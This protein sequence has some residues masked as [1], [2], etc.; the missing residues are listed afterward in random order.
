VDCRTFLCI[1]GLLCAVGCKSELGECDDTA[2]N[3][4][5]YNSSYRIATKGQALAQDSCGNSAFCHSVNAR[6]KSRHGAPG[7]MNFDMLP[8]PTGLN[9]MR[10]H[11]ELS[12]SAVERGV[13]PPGGKVGRAAIGDGKWLTD[14]QRR[15][16]ATALPPLASDAGKG[17]FRNWLAC[18]APVVVDERV[19]GQMPEVEPTW[20]SIYD[21]VIVGAGCASAGCHNTATSSGGLSLE[22]ACN[23]YAALLDKSS[24]GEVYVRPNMAAE[25][26]LVNVLEASKPRCDIDP[27]P[28]TGPLDDSAMAAIRAWIAAGAQAEC[29]N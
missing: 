9:A 13:M 27:M 15:P 6:G 2:A 12:W 11:A 22:G 26:L 7:G 16:G 4:L 24:C 21:N 20:P 25:S 17:I 3:E 14:P 29:S 19:P 1:A 10:E 8:T 5:V 28:P 18:G 23:A